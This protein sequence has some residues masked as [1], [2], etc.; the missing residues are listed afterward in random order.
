VRYV[1]RW[2]GDASNPRYCHGIWDRAGGE[3]VVRNLPGAAASWQAAVLSLRF[4]GAGERPGAHAR[5][6]DSPTC[7][8]LRIGAGRTE[9]ALLHMWA[10]EDDGWHGYLTYLER[11]PRDPG[12]W[13]PAAALRPLTQPEIEEFAER[14]DRPRSDEYSRAR[15]SVVPVDHHGTGPR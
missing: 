10:R 7:V 1:G 3:W 9:V 15:R 2:D 6:L 14:E 8:E 4:D 11:D 5:Y 12:R 13:A